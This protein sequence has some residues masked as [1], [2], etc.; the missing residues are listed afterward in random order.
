MANEGGGP[1]FAL[2][3]GSVIFG[4]VF[5]HQMEHIAREHKGYEHFDSVTPEL[6]DR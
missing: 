3:N 4:G 1:G 5:Y 6:I 2:S